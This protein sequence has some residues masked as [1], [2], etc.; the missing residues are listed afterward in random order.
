[1]KKLLAAVALTGLFAAG[2]FTVLAQVPKKEDAKPTAKADP[3][4][5][6]KKPADTKKEEPA[7]STAKGSVVVKPDAR[8]KY[9]VSIRNEDGKTLLMSSTGFTFDSEKEAIAAIEDIKSILAT[10]K[11]TVE[12]ADEKDK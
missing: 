6:P 11:V 7:K 1:M 9:R 3:K 4:A 8:G 5:D 12:K 10:S 2:T